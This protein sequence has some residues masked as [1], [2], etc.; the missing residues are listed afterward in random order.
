MEFHKNM[1]TPALGKE[2]NNLKADYKIQN[3]WQINGQEN[4][5]HSGIFEISRVS[6]RVQSH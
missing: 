1:G 2:I 4:V 6:C 5:G 3:G